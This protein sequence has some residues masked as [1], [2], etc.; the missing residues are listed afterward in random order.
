MSGGG[1]APVSVRPAVVSDAP[2]VLE[3]VR[4]LAA[5]HGKRH[6]ATLTLGS[7]LRDGF[8]PSPRF[9]AWL[10]EAD[11]A[12]VGFLQAYEGYASWPGEP[13]LVVGN[14]HVV[15]GR[16]GG[17]I[18]RAL[19][20]AALA[21]A[22]SRGIRRAELFVEE[23]NAPAIA[24]YLGLGMRRMGDLRLRIDGEALDALAGP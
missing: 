3:M 20:R 12:A 4:D 9:R 24:F 14:L 2:T 10:A 16:R 6:A 19:M 21:D 18:G 22:R 13:F 5:F 11:G 23:G 15:E 8:G 17:G 7:V 1:P